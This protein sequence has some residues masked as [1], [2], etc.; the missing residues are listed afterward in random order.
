MNDLLMIKLTCM[1]TLIVKALLIL[2][3][4]AGLSFGEVT[5]KNYDFSL[6]KLEVL[7]P[8]PFLRIHK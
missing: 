6:D 5:P 7:L 1:L 2:V 4:T 8:A 3:N